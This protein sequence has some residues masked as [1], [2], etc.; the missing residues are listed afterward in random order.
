MRELVERLMG[1]LP[2]TAAVERQGRADPI[3]DWEA[4][5]PAPHS[6]ALPA[7]DPAASL[8]PKAEAPGAVQLSLALDEEARPDWPAVRYFE[9]RGLHHRH[10]K[11]ARRVPW[12]QINAENSLAAFAYMDVARSHYE[13]LLAAWLPP[14]TWAVVDGRGRLSVAW[15]LVR[16][17]H[18]NRESWAW[19]RRKA[20]T[21]DHELALALGAR[22]TVGRNIDAPIP[23]ALHANPAASPSPW[24][25]VGWTGERYRLRHLNRRSRRSGIVVVGG[26]GMTAGGRAAGGRASGEARQVIAAER[27]ALVEK[28]VE[29]G[30]STRAIA[31]AVEAQTGRK[32]TTRTIRSDR[33]AVGLE[34]GGRK[35]AIIEG[36]RE[37]YS[38]ADVAHELEC[39]ARTVRRHRAA[40]GITRPSGGARR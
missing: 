35:K 7:P 34:L 6:A 14:A 21:I 5:G 13:A 24:Q 15:S 22:R 37:G 30:L 31:A 17:V 1:G 23:R 32:V 19:R 2:S 8:P 10:W 16:G 11:A 4:H 20:R 25:H 28:L 9:D 27:R 38:D 36:L 26:T 39:S 29:A 18:W 3:Q 33:K 40:A 12:L